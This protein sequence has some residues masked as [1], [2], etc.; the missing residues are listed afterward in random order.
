MAGPS[1]ADRSKV[2]RI[3]TT[4]LDANEV[5]ASIA[6]QW[7][8]MVC[9]SGIDGSEAEENPEAL[10][11]ALKFQQKIF[12]NRGKIN[13]EFHP[14][15]TLLSIVFFCWFYMFQSLLHS[16]EGVGVVIEELEGDL[17]LQLEVLQEVAREVLQLEVQ[18]VLHKEEEIFQLEVL[19]AVVLLGV[20]EVLHWK[21]QIICQVLQ[22]GVLHL[23]LVPHQEVDLLGDGVDLL[24]KDE[25][26]LGDVALVDNQG[27]EELYEEEEHV[28]RNQLLLLLLNL[29][30][31]TNQ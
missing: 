19:Q 12:S 3:I 26:L 11:N 27:E 23:I 24:L 7:E 17:L 15:C 16:V 1:A 30:I 5:Q 10:L 28:H 18:E 9:S 6:S 13:S 14:L 21:H 20:V 25:V 31:W 2:N 8:A 22:K 29:L 4:F